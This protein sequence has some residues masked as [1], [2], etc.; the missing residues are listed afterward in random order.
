M[1]YCSISQVRTLTNIASSDV[2][3]TAMSALIDI[4]DTYCDSRLSA[5]GIPVPVPSPVPDTLSLA[6]ANFTSALCINR[7][8]VDL[9]RPA[10]LSL[11]G[12]LGFSTTP[13]TEISYFETAGLRF[14][15]A[16][17]ADATGSYETVIDVVEGE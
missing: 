17:I 11:G 16:F 5:A 14:L 1:G 9:S 13:D 3:D 8:R 15:A 10:S 4:A 2:D 7:K 12:E 6:C